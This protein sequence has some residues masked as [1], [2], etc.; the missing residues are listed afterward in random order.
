[1]VGLWKSPMCINGVGCVNEKIYDRLWDELGWLTH[2][3]DHG[4]QIH[5][6]SSMRLC[7]RGT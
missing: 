2:K 1:V 6:M 7:K 5:V 3:D 4:R